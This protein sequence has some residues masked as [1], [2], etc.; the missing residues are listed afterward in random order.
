MRSVYLL[1][2]RIAEGGQRTLDM[3]KVTNVQDWPEPKTG[4]DIERFLGVVNYFR[5]FIPAASH[6]TKC[7]DKLRKAPSLQGLWTAQH[8]QAFETL[9]K[10]L[11]VHPVLH[12]VDF[13]KQLY[14]ATDASNVGIAAVLYQFDENDQKNTSVSKLA[15]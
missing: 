8:K 7:M 12:P 15:L 10:I 2:F 6:L 1:G 11:L 5:N 14:V 9:K 13:S 4:K 3:R